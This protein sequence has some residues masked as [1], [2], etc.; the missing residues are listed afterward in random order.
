[1][2][3]SKVYGHIIKIYVF[4]IGNSIIFFVSKILTFR[5]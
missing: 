1:M 2:K 4:K 5:V 3:G